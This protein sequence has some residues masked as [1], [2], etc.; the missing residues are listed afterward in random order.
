[1]TN[2]LNL[3]LEAASISQ[4]AIEGQ[5]LGHGFYSRGL[6]LPNGTALRA[7]YKGYE[8]RAKIEND[9]WIDHLENRHFSPTGAAKAITGNSVNGWRFWEA[10]RP[11]DSKWRR[12]D[13]LG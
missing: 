5:V 4:R 9:A 7:R 11:G 13:L 12:L 3:A 2:L 8:Y 1:M 10:W 6:T